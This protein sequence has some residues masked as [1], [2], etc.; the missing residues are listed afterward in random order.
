MDG[1][2]MPT[3]PNTSWWK[4]AWPRAAVLAAAMCAATLATTPSAAADDQGARLVAFGTSLSVGGRWTEPLSERLAACGIPA[5]R[6]AVI[7]APGAGS[8]WAVRQ[9]D[10]VI[11][12]EPDVVVIEF[13]I[14]DADIL[15]GLWLDES[16]R[17]H[18]RILTRLRNAL[19]DAHLALMT[20]N[21]AFGLRGWVRPFLDDYYAMYRT[22]AREADVALID[23]TP[24]WRRALEHGEA[25]AA[26]PDG[27]HPTADAVARIAVPE[28]AR[29]VRPLLPAAPHDACEPEA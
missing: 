1:S 16:R 25:D 24:H 13:A 12:A 15:D 21:P 20:T 4:K 11:A 17:N 27:L 22:M 6:T 5:P 9:I 7:A 10:R 26:I 28:I 29:V 3:R 18:R 2:R 19:P 23:T 8:D 14:N